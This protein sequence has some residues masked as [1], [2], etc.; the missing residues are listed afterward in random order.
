MLIDKPDLTPGPEDIFEARQL[1]E[2]LKDG[3]DA[4]SMGQR[5]AVVLYYLEG[6]TQEEIAQLLGTPASAIKT[7]LQKARRKLRAIL[8]RPKEEEVKTV[9]WVPMDL[10]DVR[11]IRNPDQPLLYGAVLS[12]PDRDR[13]LVIFM[14]AFEG[15]SIA[16]QLEKVETA[17]PMTYKFMEE[18]LRAAAIKVIE[19]RVEKLHDHTYLATAV[20]EGPDG[21]K[22]V[23]ARPSD[24]FNLAIATGA[25][26]VVHP[27]VLDATGITPD[28]DVWRKLEEAE[29]NGKG[30]QKIV[31]R[32][33][34][35]LRGTWE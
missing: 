23:D 6:L 14:G 13:K 21:T 1:Q 3:L 17:R 12:E 34:E 5:E 16:T 15:T 25:R 22:E 2:R 10:V 18:V 35:P 32:M 33:A 11:V 31:R 28:S 20:V 9:E 7:R 4:I 19:V 8:E 24:A 30:S 27:E 29:A 26:I